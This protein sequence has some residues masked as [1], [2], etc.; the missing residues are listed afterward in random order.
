LRRSTRPVQRKRVTRLPERPDSKPEQERQRPQGKS[1]GPMMRTRSAPLDPAPPQINQAPVTSSSS[2]ASRKLG[3]P[4]APAAPAAQPARQSRLWNAG[5]PAGLAALE[6]RNAAERQALLRQRPQ[7][8]RPQD[9]SSQLDNEII[10]LREDDEDDANEL[11]PNHS[12]HPPERRHRRGLATA[13]RRYR[14]SS[15]R[16]EQLRTRATH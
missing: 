2:A 16:C 6:A 10:F 15:S 5:G 4:I 1:Q 3:Q 9:P 14:S 12:I 13:T 8:L 7:R 11:S